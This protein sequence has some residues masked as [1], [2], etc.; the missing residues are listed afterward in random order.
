M[1]SSIPVSKTVAAL[2]GVVSATGAS[3]STEVGRKEKVG[4]AD[5][6][7]DEVGCEVMV[8]PTVGDFDEVGVDD[9]LGCAETVGDMDGRSDEDGFD[10]RLGDTL[11]RTDV[12]GLYD[13]VDCVVGVDKFGVDQLGVDQLWD[14]E[15]DAFP[16]FDDFLL[17]FDVFPDLD[18][19]ESS[20][21]RLTS[22]WDRVLLV[23]PDLRIG[24]E[25]GDGEALDCPSEGAL[26]AKDLSW[27]IPTPRPSHIITGDAIAIKTTA[28]NRRRSAAP[29]SDLYDVSII[30]RCE[31]SKTMYDT[32]VSGCFWEML[33]GKFE[34][35]TYTHTKNKER[36]SNAR[37]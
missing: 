11:G 22:K 3:S 18:P 4:E 31:F 33:E 20:D 10:E 8:G 19:R 27:I 15:F 35:N 23:L 9:T 7:P 36:C 2:S 21:A 1:S 30:R 16:D 28:S 24:P 13:N 5:G 26:P 6:R 17:I 29:S 32:C 37:S 12:V 34:F 25:R 14:N